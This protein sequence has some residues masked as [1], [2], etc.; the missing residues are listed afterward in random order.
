M[1]TVKAN[2]KTQFK[3]KLDC[4]LCKNSVETQ[5]HLF[6]C[7]ELK[8]TIPELS[9]NDNVKYAHIFGTITE[10]KSAIKLIKKIC[11]EREKQIEKFNDYK[12]DD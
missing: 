6:D 1:Y 10:M 3:N 5:E 2:F 11:E 7:T 12:D 9:N 8:K 4:K